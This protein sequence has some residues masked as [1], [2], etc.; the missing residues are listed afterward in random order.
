MFIIARP[1]CLSLVMVLLKHV[2]RRFNVLNDLSPSAK[3][4]ICTKRGAHRHPN[5]PLATP[6]KRTSPTSKQI[7]IKLISVSIIFAYQTVGGTIVSNPSKAYMSKAKASYQLGNKGGK[8]VRALASQKCGLCSNLGVNAICE[9]SLLLS[10][11]LFS[12]TFCCS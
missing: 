5:T 4:Q 2:F 10:E 11:R 3:L 8:A 6:L 1:D 7:I 9:L 12:G